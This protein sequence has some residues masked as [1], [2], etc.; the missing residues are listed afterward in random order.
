MHLRKKRKREPVGSR[1][2]VE[3]DEDQTREIKEEGEQKKMMAI[4]IL[5]I[6]VFVVPIIALSLLFVV[7]ACNMMLEDEGQAK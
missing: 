2:M 5:L 7:S 3:N 4:K 6:G 1:R